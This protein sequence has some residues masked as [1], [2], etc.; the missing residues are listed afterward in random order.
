MCRG[1]SYSDV[2]ELAQLRHK[3]LKEALV[4]LV[5]LASTTAAWARLDEIYGNRKMSVIMALKRLKGFK[6]TKS[7]IHDRII[8]VATAVQRCTTV[9]QALDRGQDLLRNREAIAEVLNLLPAD[10]QCAWYRRK[11]RLEEA[12]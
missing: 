12:P 1:E 6:P 8:K 4:I 5:G 2:I 7:A 9:L 10:S 11:P 3:L